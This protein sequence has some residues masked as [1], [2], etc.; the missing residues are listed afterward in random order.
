MFY[1]KLFH[2]NLSRLLNNEFKIFFLN[3]LNVN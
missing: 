2:I 1:Y 3:Q